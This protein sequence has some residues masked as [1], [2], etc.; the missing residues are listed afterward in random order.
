MLSIWNGG[1]W[2]GVLLE[3]TLLLWMIEGNWIGLEIIERSCNWNRLW[4]NRYGP[5]GQF[6]PPY[7]GHG[8]KEAGKQWAKKDITRLI[9]WSPDPGSDLSGHTAVGK[10]SSQRG[11]SL[12]GGGGEEARCSPLTRWTTS[13]Q[14]SV[15]VGAI[16]DGGPTFGG[17][18][19]G[20][21]LK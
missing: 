20:E 9:A 13:T 14:I 17:G 16:E 7:K 6:R 2:S 5:F 8:M 10:P 19:K 15:N 4:W 21:M 1:G 12:P 3:E 11:S 18:L